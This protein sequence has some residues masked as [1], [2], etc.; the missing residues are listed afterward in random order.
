V[1]LV[2]RDGNEEVLPLLSKDQVADEI[3]DRVEKLLRDRS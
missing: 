3:L 2:S 1:T